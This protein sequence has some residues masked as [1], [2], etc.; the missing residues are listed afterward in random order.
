MPDDIKSKWIITLVIVLS[1]MATATVGYAYIVVLPSITSAVVQN[2][3]IRE[4]E[5][6]RIEKQIREIELEDRRERIELQKV[7]NSQYT[8]II[9]RLSRMEALNERG[10]SWEK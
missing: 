3:R 2:D 7:I 5:D 6:K 8:E 4:G 1:G 9:Q 10:Q